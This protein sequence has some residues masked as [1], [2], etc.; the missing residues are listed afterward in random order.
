MH[1]ILNLKDLQC[2]VLSYELRSFSRAAR[3]APKINSG[4][5]RRHP[6]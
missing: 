3:A 2:F 1:P 6:M 5:S 4:F